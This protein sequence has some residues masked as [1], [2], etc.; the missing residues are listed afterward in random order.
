[1][2][3]IRPHPY[4][5]RARAKSG[6]LAASARD[7]V[8]K[9]LVEHKR[10]APPRTRP[11]LP[12]PLPWS[13]GDCV[14]WRSVWN[15]VSRFGFIIDSSTMRSSLISL[16]ALFASAD[17]LVVGAGSRRTTSSRLRGGAKSPQML[18]F[19]K[20]F[21]PKGRPTDAEVTQTVY[22]DMEIGGKPAGRIEMGLFGGVVPKTAENFRALCTGEKGMG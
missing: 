15:L 17:A 22:F 19:L 13:A 1:M 14:V 8:S 4:E 10:T 5:R 3:L 12:H 7:S 16:V 11:Y 20:D 18:D 6:A 9:Y 2:Q 21:L